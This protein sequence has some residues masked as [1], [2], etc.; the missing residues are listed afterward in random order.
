MA[1]G[2]IPGPVCEEQTFTPIDDGTLSL[3]LSPLPAPLGTSKHL[4]SSEFEVCEM[5]LHHESHFADN[6]ASM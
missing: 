3:S 2:E 1:G 4:F 5:Y 6:H